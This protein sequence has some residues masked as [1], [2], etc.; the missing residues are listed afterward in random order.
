MT[1]TATAAPVPPTDPAAPNKP[2]RARTVFASIALVVA[3]VLTPFGTLSYS[4]HETLVNQARYLE[5]VGPIVADPEV[6]SVIAHAATDAIV[7]QVDLTEVVQNTLGGLLGDN[8]SDRITGMLV[9]P[10]ANGL[11]N[12]I[13]EAVLRAVASPQFE[14][15][16]IATNTAAQ[17]S[18]IALLEGRNEGIIQTQGETIVIDVN[19]LINGVRAELSQREGFGFLERVPE[20]T[21]PRVLPIATVPGLEMAQSIFRYANPMFGFFPLLLVLL[22]AAAIVLSRRRARMTIIV[23]GTLFLA[24]IVT[25]VFAHQVWD[26]FANGL[27]NTPFE[28][29]AGAFWN[30]YAN[31]LLRGIPILFLLAVL[32]LIAGIVWTVLQRR[33]PRELPPPAETAVLPTV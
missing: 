17:K 31:A 1:I 25:N 3:F 19:Q 20:L 15:A 7:A 18:L 21:T 28:A 10:L 13:Y 6:Q 23:G 24:A 30:A 22:Y 11:Q 14:S 5:T 2:G 16:W 8:A 9:G 32:V 26:R 29:A 4:A 33:A 27:D 12:L